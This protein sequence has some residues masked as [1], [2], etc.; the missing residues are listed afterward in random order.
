MN[1]DDIFSRPPSDVSCTID[2]INISIWIRIC[3]QSQWNKFYR[4][5]IRRGICS[6]TND[7][8]SP[9]WQTGR[10]QLKQNKDRGETRGKSKVWR[11]KMSQ[12]RG[13]K[14]RISSFDKNM[15]LVPK[16]GHSLLLFFFFFLSLS[17]C[18]KIMTVRATGDAL[19]FNWEVGISNI[20]E[21]T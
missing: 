21:R 9:M 17:Y 12:N 1:L 18:K 20:Q 14:Y 16:G 2:Q 15:V 8:V 3:V 11:K 5:C 6:S 19:D 10:E 7:F 4:I 13:N